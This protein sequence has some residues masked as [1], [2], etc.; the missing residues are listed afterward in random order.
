[1]SAKNN[2]CTINPLAP[3]SIH[4]IDLCFFMFPASVRRII[5]RQRWSTFKSL[6]SQVTEEFEIPYDEIATVS[7][8]NHY[9]QTNDP[10][11]IKF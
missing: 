9:S 6:P 5:G 3:T 8:K 11:F 7:L 1:M 4:G 2:Y 10:I